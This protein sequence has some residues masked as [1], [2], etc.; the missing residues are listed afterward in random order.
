MTMTPIHM[1]HHGHGLG[2]IGLVIGNHIGSMYPPSLVTDVLVDKVGRTAMAIAAEVT[3]LLAGL[4]AAFAP[5]DSILV[6][7]IALSLLGVGWNFGLISG[8]A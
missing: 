6:L 2:A 7:I 3:L 5:S 8:T 1:A 4:L